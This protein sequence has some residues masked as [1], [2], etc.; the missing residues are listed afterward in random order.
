MRDRCN[1]NQH[2]QFEYWGGRGIKVCERWN[3]DFSSYWR[4]MR[5]LNL[6]PL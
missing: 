5:Q 1:N 3:D 6:F 4:K 2:P